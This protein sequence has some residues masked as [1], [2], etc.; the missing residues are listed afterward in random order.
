MKKTML[1]LLV[2]AGLVLFPGNAKGQ[3]I[4]SNQLTDYSGYYWLEEVISS[5]DMVSRWQEGRRGLERESVYGIVYRVRN[6]NNYAHLIG[7]VTP[8]QFDVLYDIRQDYIRI[9][10]LLGD[11]RLSSADIRSMLAGFNFDSRI[12]YLLG[13]RNQLRVS[14]GYEYMRP[15]DDIESRIYTPGGIPISPSLRKQIGW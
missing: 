15:P 1:F 13:I 5:L 14:P 2:V 7:K 8:S 12:K 4:A 3:Q 6:N 11:R 9:Y 10:G